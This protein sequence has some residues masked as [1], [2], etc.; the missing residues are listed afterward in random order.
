MFERRAVRLRLH[1]RQLGRSWLLRNR[2]QSVYPF[3]QRFDDHDD[4]HHDHDVYVYFDFD[5]DHHVRVTV[6]APV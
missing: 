6:T 3:V 5:F 4:H 1:L 2:L